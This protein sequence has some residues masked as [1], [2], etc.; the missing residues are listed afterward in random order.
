MNL[1][2]EMLEILTG[3]TVIVSLAVSGGVIAFVGSLLI[4][5]NNTEQISTNKLPRVAVK[6]GYFISFASVILFIIAGFLG[7]D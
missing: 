7:V 3:K 2:Q 4:K 5:N 6:I 1:N